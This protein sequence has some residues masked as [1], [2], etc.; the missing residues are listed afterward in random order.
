MPFDFHSLPRPGSG[1]A[2]PDSKSARPRPRGERP[3]PDFEPLKVADGD[4]SRFSLAA[5]LLT[6][7]LGCLVLGIGRWLPPALFA[8]I[9]GFGLLA[10]GTILWVLKAR[11]AIWHMSWW[12][13]LAIYLFAVGLA[14]SGAC[15]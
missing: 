8:G 1:P 14:V 3:E 15:P 2:S 12:V 10:Y 13:L 6:L 4:E 11:A 5:A 7:T 9:T